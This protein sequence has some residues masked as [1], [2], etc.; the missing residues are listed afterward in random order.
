MNALDPDANTDTNINTNTNTYT[1]ASAKSYVVTVL[2]CFF[3][4]CFGAHR[5]YVGKI[6][7]AVL[8]LLTLGGFGIWAIVDLIVI[9]ICN[10]KD[11]NG[12]SILP[13][14]IA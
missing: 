13:R 9:I 8:M 11:A 7:T 6:G 5:F 1:N 10:F 14:R 12:F 3:L 2:L 4:G